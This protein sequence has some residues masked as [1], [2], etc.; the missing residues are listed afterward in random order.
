[1]TPNLGKINVPILNFGHGNQ[2]LLPKKDTKRSTEFPAAAL[3]IAAK[4]RALRIA[5]AEGNALIPPNVGMT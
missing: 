2:K 5:R 1:M 3:G 4:C